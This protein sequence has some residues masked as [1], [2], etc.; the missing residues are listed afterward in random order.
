MRPHIAVN[1][2]LKIKDI[3][4][5]IGNTVQSIR[6]TFSTIDA[7][8]RAAILSYG[9]YNIRMKRMYANYQTYRR[10]CVDDGEEFPD[11]PVTNVVQNQVPVVI[12]HD[13]NEKDGPGG[14]EGEISDSDPI[15]YTIFF[16]NTPTATASAQ[17][18]TIIDDLSDLFDWDTFTLHEVAFSDRT[19]SI[20]NVHSDYYQ[21]VV[22]N[23]Y[24][25]DIES[26]INSYTGRARWILTM[27]DPKTETLPLDGGVGFLPPNNPETG[28]GEG[29]VTFSIDPIPGLESG[30]EIRNKAEIIFDA[31]QPIITNET[32]HTISAPSPDQPITMAPLM[33]AVLSPPQLNL[34]G[35]PYLHPQNL[36]QKAAQFEIRD[37]AFGSITWESGTLQSVTEVF[38]PEGN[39]SLDRQYLWRVRYQDENNNWSAWSDYGWFQTSAH[40]PTGDIDGNG[41]INQWDL[42]LLIEN[43]RL[44]TRGDFD[45][46]QTVDYR[47]L[48]IFSNVW[49]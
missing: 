30:T 35:S 39:L 16:E 14:M 38:V 27:I 28:D 37:Y 34:K 17:Q 31:N 25:I 10:H 29:H 19:I 9:A 8:E 41:I 32:M 2:L 20:F 13:P 45:G 15:T 24:A 36:N 11:P 43:W 33:G 12:P 4:K 44:S 42:L 5:Q 18:V 49:K 23:N 47:D 1:P 3:Y 6:D 48:F 22:F 26:R 40:S 21:R 46:N 7:V